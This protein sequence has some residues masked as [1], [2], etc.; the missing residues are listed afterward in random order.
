MEQNETSQV[1]LLEEIKDNASLI[2]ELLRKAEENK[3]NKE[4]VDNCVVAMKSDGE[5][6]EGSDDYVGSFGGI[7][8]SIVDA[9]IDYGKSFIDA[10]NE[11]IQKNTGSDTAYV[12]EELELISDYYCKNKGIDKEQLIAI[13]EKYS[14]DE[15]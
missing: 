5:K 9:V 3:H 11:I 2:K 7:I 1:S 8:S 14:K 10:F 12:E 4:L 6:V 13:L 15:S